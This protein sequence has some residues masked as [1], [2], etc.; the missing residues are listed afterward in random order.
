MSTGQMLARVPFRYVGQNLERGE[1]FSLRGSPRDNQLLG[2]GYMIPFDKNE[3]R[4]MACDNCG[5]HFATEGFYIAHKSKKGGCL[6]PSPDITKGETAML[7]N[8]DLQKLTV[9]E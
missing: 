7:L 2:I 5:K 9:E 4:D 8:I 1:L 3:H 6:A